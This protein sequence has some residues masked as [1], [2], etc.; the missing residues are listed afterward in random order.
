MSDRGGPPGERSLRSVWDWTVDPIPEALSFLNEPPLPDGVGVIVPGQR[1]SLH[2]H[3]AQS[4]ADTESLLVQLTRGVRCADSKGLLLASSMWRPCGCR[5]R[6][7]FYPLV[8]SPIPKQSTKMM[9]PDA[10]A[11]H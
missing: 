1:R 11:Q 2:A 3:I 5:K 7:S 8:A 4:L 6:L 9:S 10:S